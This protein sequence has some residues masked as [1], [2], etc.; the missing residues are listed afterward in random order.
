M[1]L[2]PLF[3]ALVQTET[4]G[5]TVVTAPRTTITAT[6][7]KAEVTVV[8][9][10]DLEKTGER[11]L[12]RA[13]G[14]AAGIWIQES[15]T[16]G[17]APIIR[18][19]YGNRILIVIDGVR[20]NDS[21]TR[22][23][24]N[25]SLNTIDPA[26]VD[27]IE[28]YHGT[29]SV[30]YGSDAIGGVIAIWTKSRS[31]ASQT[32]SG[33]RSLHGGAELEYNSS[34][35]G[36]SASDSLSGATDDT[37]LLGI[38]SAWNFHDLEVGG[39]EEVP[40]GYHGNAAFGSWEQAV[41]AQQT[42]RVTGMSHR[43]FDVQ[44]TFSLVTGFGQTEPAY[45]LYNF[46]IQDR[47]RYIV[48][49]DD[50]E[51]NALSDTMQLRLSLRD[52]TEQSERLRTGG[53]TLT[54]TEYN[55][56]TTGLGGDW[57]KELAEGNSL[58][59]GFD[60]DHDELES[61]ARETDVDTGDV[62]SINGP[63]ADGGK[64][65]SFGVFVQDEI[66]SIEAYAFT[67]GLRFSH[68]AFDF[69]DP[70][71]GEEHDEA[72]DAVT[73]SA[74]AAR[75]LTE[76]SRLS[77]T[78]AQG[79]RAPGF[80]DVS[81]PENPPFGGTELGNPDL[82]PETSLTAQLAYE[83]EKDRWNAGVATFI[84]EIEDAI[85]RRLIDPGDINVSGDETY[86]RDNTGK[87]KFYGVEVQGEHG[88]FEDGSPW[89]IEGAAAYVRGRQ[90]DDTIDPNTGEAPFDGVEGRRIPPL[91]G[92]LAL[93]WEEAQRWTWLDRAELA[94]IWAAEQDHLNPEDMID[95]RI[96]P[97]GT[98]AWNVFDL[99]FTGPISPDVRWSVAFMNL[100]DEEYRVHASG[101]D[102]PGRSL[103]VG[104]TGGF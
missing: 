5:E 36:W 100:F 15:N 96:D 37:G 65:D 66:T 99:H 61:F 43:D 30:R 18:G 29:A 32:K 17:G 82:D 9:G 87:L 59:Y 2:P 48:S 60:Y 92:Y 69:E 72:F 34:V 7:T 28:V 76:D 53:S 75:E 54:F 47:Q 90:Y 103:V 84:T 89:S 56:Q 95:P 22:L 3:L 23:G 26:I 74:S 64:Y 11:S 73:A 21:T 25:Q 4:L 49:Y 83:I 19:V 104:V 79:F 31:A 62:E 14:R 46:K 42:I 71:T 80:E 27:R 50:R 38:L 101:F 68:F 88:L 39:G 94:W 10:E 58:S 40:S 85:G 77:A 45:E 33:D 97:E 12:P 52:Y 57:R 70:N 35:E 86:L 51:S 81:N 8:T 24:P 41:G 1:F 6:T 16:G 20:M 44:R 91:N 63:L 55:V 78:L 102:G 98:D 13:L 93:V 67:V